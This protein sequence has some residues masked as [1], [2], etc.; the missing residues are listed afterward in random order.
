MIKKT[1][2]LSDERANFKKL[3]AEQEMEEREPYHYTNECC[4][5]TDVVRHGVRGGMS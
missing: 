4:S 3:A 2:L 1:I 5:T